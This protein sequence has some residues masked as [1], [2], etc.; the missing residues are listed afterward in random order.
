MVGGELS[1]ALSGS[2]HR[3]SDGLS[4]GCI[5]NKNAVTLVDIAGCHALKGPRLPR[6]EGQ[7]FPARAI[8][9]SVFA[10]G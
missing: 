8:S 4:H 3:S 5:E 10:L 6:R 7:Y 2:G 1:Q 9:Q